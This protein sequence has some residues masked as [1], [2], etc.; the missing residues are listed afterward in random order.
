VNVT[1][2][3]FRVWLLSDSSGFGLVADNAA[4]SMTSA[5]MA[6]VIGYSDITLE[7]TGSAS[8]TSAWDINQNVTIPF[9]TSYSSSTSGVYVLL[10]ATGAYTPGF[11]GVFTIKVMAE[12]W[13]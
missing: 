8:S 1:N 11:G 5:K 4:L 13:R 2:A 12:E 9:V 7:T 6:K 3:T 10:S